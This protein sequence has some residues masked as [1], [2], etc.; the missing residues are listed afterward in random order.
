MKNTRLKTSITF[1]VIFG[2]AIMAGCILNPKEKDDPPPNNNPW[3]SLANPEGI[4]QTLERCYKDRNAEKYRE[5][6]LDPKYLFYLQ[7]R[8]V[9]GGEEE[10]WNLEEDYDSVR[11][12]F[13]AA[14]GAPDGN[15]PLLNRLDLTIEG[16]TWTDVDSIGDEACVDCRYTERIYDVTAVIGE[17]TY[18]AHDVIALYVQPVE[19]QGMTIY[20]IRRAYDLPQR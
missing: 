6:L 2:F 12:M 11:R 20:K 3:P 9:Q 8:D 14:I 7:E 10:F 17:T 18:L 13:L 16:G 15:D 4:V 5:I 19:E 1:L